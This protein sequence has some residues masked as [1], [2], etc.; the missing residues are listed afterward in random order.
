MNAYTFVSILIQIHI[1]SAY[2]I[3]IESAKNEFN[4]FFY[5]IISK[6]IF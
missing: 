5:N 1:T 4:D 6:R 3:K 2:C